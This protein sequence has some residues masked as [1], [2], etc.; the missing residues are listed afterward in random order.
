MI[1]DVAGLRPEILDYAMALESR[2]GRDLMIT[3]GVRT[4]GSHRRG[5]EMDL[6][7]RGG[8]MRRQL[9]SIALDLAIPRIGVYDKHLHIGC[10][11]YEVLNVLWAGVSK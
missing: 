5:Y 7:V 3:S 4:S 2:F 10:D 11:P 6:R 8:W 1:G 9:V